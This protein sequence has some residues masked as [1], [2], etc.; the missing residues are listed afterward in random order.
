MLQ[1]LA[2]VILDKLDHNVQKYSLKNNNGL[3]SQH[4]RTGVNYVTSLP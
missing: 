2:L 1:Q 3:L 4:A